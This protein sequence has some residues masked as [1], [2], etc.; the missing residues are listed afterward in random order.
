M[1]VSSDCFPLKIFAVELVVYLSPNWIILMLSTCKITFFFFL[2]SH[3]KC[4]P[5]LKFFF[6]IITVATHF[7]PVLAEEK[8]ERKV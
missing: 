6:I 4:I 7:L 5:P 8:E 2:L 3:A 1:P